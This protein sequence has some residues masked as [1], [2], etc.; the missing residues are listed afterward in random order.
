MAM[1]ETSSPVTGPSL[2][3]TLVALAIFVIAIVALSFLSV[4]NA[5]WI[6]AAFGIGFYVGRELAHS[7]RPSEPTKFDIKWSNIRQAGWPSGVL[8]AVASSIK[9]F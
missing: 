9:Y 8:I 1:S 3:H 7:F 4:A 6:A 2:S 5:Q